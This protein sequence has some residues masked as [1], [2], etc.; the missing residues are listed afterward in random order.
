MGILADALVI[1]ICGIFGEKIKNH[2]IS[3]YTIGIAIMMLSLV[4]FLENMYNINGKTLSTDNLIIVLL[5]FIAGSKIGEV[6]RLEERLSNL[7]RTDNKSLNAFVDATL[8]F[9]VG[10]LQISGPIALA[11]KHSN[12]QLFIKSLVDAPFA[13]IFGST[14]GKIAA[15]S[16][17]PVALL[18]VGIAIVAYMFSSFLTQTL[19]AEI[20]AMGYIILF[21]SGFNLMT[22]GKVK[23][24]N[25]N[26]IPG[27]GLVVLFDIVKIVIGRLL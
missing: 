27:I 7:G 18:Q 10:G 22:D 13:L 4:S 3:N 5:A 21:F 25:T 23:I 8:F 26:M 20:C 14:Y 19:I 9:G 6:I 11:L 17:I 1:C 15:V 16:A 24:S 12:D 2:K